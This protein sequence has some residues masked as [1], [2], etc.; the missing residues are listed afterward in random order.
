MSCTHPTA[1]AAS[2]GVCPICPP[3]STPVKVP[4]L[5]KPSGTLRSVL[6]HRARRDAA[7]AELARRSLA[8]F[9][10]QAWPYVEGDAELV[11]HW[12]LDAVCDHVQAQLQDWA[13]AR[14]YSADAWAGMV[15][16]GENASTLRAQNQVINLPPRCLKTVIA[17]VCASAWAWLH[18]PEMRVITFSS[19]PRVTSGASRKFAQL[20]R[21]D[22]YRRIADG[23][24]DQRARVAG[25]PPGWARWTIPKE[26]AD[27]EVVNEWVDKERGGAPGGSRKARGMESAFVGEGA[28][29]LLCDDAHAAADVWSDAKRTSVHAKW[30]DEVFSRVN[31][32]TRSVRTIVMQ[33][34]HPDDLVAHVLQGAA[35]W[36]VLELPMEE[37][38]R[39]SARAPDWLGWRDPREPG[40]RCVL[41]PARFPSA[42]VA[43]L[44]RA[45]LIWNAQYQQRP[46]NLEGGMFKRRDWRFW[47]PAGFP[48][49]ARPRPPGCATREES[50]ARVVPRDRWGKLLFDWVALSVDPTFKKTQDGSRVGLVVVAGLGPDRFV[51]HD[52][53]RRMSY[54]EY[55]EAL[56]ALV[57]GDVARQADLTGAADA[58]TCARPALRWLLVEDKASGSPTVDEIRAP[59]PSGAA[60]P[61]RVG[62][63]SVPAGSGDKVARAF[64]MSA[65][66][67]GGAWYLLDGAPWLEGTCGDDDDLGFLQEVSVFPNGKRD[68]R[69]DAL[70]QCHNHF[71]EQASEMACWKGW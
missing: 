3:E 15:E 45:P 25:R 29:W 8:E 35:Q 34:L 32:P 42:F 70:S 21:S 10:R 22:W 40:S 49:P 12:H 9:V 16:R 66:V 23:A 18:W 67:A 71:A 20:V 50:P 61:S 62:V 27:A 37:D 11:W 38:G 39:A 43:E 60:W 1:R 57:G 31:D 17:T 41:H 44:K 28:D 13:R 46:E 63:V 47:S 58:L 68:D 19:N 33:R 53:S 14:Q 26:A 69:V 54:P 5:P 4:R 52:A 7:L 59:S 30:D 48:P 64:A 55:K 36:R 56:R 2:G 24:A 65:T 51:L 6:Y